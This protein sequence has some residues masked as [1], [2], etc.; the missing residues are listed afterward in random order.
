V[1]K[2][3]VDMKYCKEITNRIKNKSLLER[4]K[5]PEE[6]AMLFEDGMVIGASGFTPTGYPK[7]V[8]VAVAE[9]VKNG[10]K[11]KFYLQ[12]GASIGSE[13]DELWSKNQMLYM[14]LP[15]Q[16]NST[17]RKAIN[18]NETDYT[19]M[20]LSHTPRM[21]K[22]GVLPQPDIAI[23]EVVA[24]TEEGYLVPPAA[25][26]NA[27]TFAECAKQII[28]EVNVAASE[29]LTGMADIYIMDSPPHSK[30][31]MI[32]HP[33]DRIGST[34]I[35]C[36][37][38][39]ISAIVISDKRDSTRALKK[40]DVVS[41]QISAH[42]VDFL[43]N[44]VKAC[45]MPEN[46]NPL[47]SGVGSV[48]NAVFE[49]LGKSDFKG[50]TCYTEVVQDAMLDLIRM[51]KIDIVSATSISPSPE[52]Y[53]AFEK[54]IEFFRDKIILRPQEIS[55]NPE[56]ARR[57]G[58]I[59][60]NTALEFDIYGNVNSTHVRGSRMMNGIGGSGDFAR[61]AA[62]TIFACPSAAKEGTVSAV[63]PMVSHV[64]HTEH[65]VMVVVTEY[66]LADLRGLAPRKRAELIIEKCVHPDFKDYL[67]NYYNEAC[68]KTGGHTPHILEKALVSPVSSV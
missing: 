20:H 16:T 8:P 58:L 53:I 42:I 67:R 62:L 10:E 9:R 19:D 55:N 13:F 49:G 33:S 15:Y 40:A 18:S 7:V 39:K 46:L 36:D 22:T 12:T 50:M 41:E 66:G 21:I 35:K 61:N 31:I 17:L 60:I 27:A 3:G 1:E 52:A 2:K 56:V 4:I 32:T 6:A 11:M 28:L 68:E 64:D 26:G 48:A 5:T 14:R 59:A 63:V 57:L 44:E 45:R 54:D 23:L 47:Q 24:I 30:P 37:L 38:N 34:V 29:L 51:G 25:I 65:D 43:K